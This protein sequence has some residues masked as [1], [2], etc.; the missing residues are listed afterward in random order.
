[1]NPRDAFQNLVVVVRAYKGT[2]EEHQ[3]LQQSLRVIAE[4]LGL[5]RSNGEAPPNAAVQP[6]SGEQEST[7]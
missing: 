1:M 3:A 6:D 4:A 5:T 2:W 7:E